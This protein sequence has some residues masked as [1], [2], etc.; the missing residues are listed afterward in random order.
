MDAVVQGEHVAASGSPDR[1][2][3]PNRLLHLRG[4]S[5]RQQVATVNVPHQADGGAV[6]GL[7]FPEDNPDGRWRYFP[8]E[9]LAKRDKLNLDIFWIK[10]DSLSE[11]E[12]LPEPDVLALEIAKDLEAALAQF[13]EIVNGLGEE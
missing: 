9:E 4:R 11:S 3:G 13:R 6:D 5:V 7:H 1:D 10:H 2:C 8:H 12:N